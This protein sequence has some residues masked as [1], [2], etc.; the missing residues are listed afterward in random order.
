MN[1]KTIAE[2][3]NQNPV[4]I[5]EFIKKHPGVLKRVGKGMGTKFSV[6]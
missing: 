6:G 3:L 4:R 5:R 1:A 2:K